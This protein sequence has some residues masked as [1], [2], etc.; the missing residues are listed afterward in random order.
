MNHGLEDYMKKIELLAPVGTKE[1]LVAAV[2]NGADAVYLAGKAF[3]A[4]KFAGNFDEEEMK[5][6][7]AFCHK[8]GVSVFVTVNTLIADSEF[9]QLIEYIDF[10]Y[11]ADVD[12]VIVQDFGVLKMIRQRYPDFE[13]HAST[14]MTAHSTEDMRYLQEQGVKRVVLPR[15]MP[16]NEIAE[17]RKQTDMD[18]ECFVHGALC[19][20]YS[21][22][23]LMS[24]MIGG[25]SGNRGSCAQ[26][27]RQPYS[28]V[29]VNTGLTEKHNSGKYLLSPKDLRAL[30]EVP[31]LIRAGVNSFK[32]EGRMKRP[33][34][35]AVVVRAYRE[36][37][38]AAL[39]KKPFDLKAWNE[40]TAAIFTRGFTKGHLFGDK[41]EDRMNPLWPGHS[42]VKIGSVKNYEKDRKRMKIWI[43]HTLN[44]GDEVQIRRGNESVGARV[45]FIEIARARVKSAA[46]GQEIIMNMQ[47]PVRPGEVIYRTVDDSL[48]KEAR[49]SYARQVQRVEVEIAL[50]IK[51]GEAIT[52]QIQDKEGHR[53]FVEGDQPE[54]A[55]KRPLDAERVEKQIMKLGDSPYFCEAPVINLEDGLALPM[56]SLNALRRLALDELDALRVTRYS[57]RLE[58]VAI[59]PEEIVEP[60]NEEESYTTPEFNVQ[61]RTKEQFSTALDVGVDA[62]LVSTLEMLRFALDETEEN[63]CKVIFAPGRIVRDVEFETLNNNMELLRESAGIWAGTYGVI[64]WA[65]ENNLAV[66]GIDQ[67][68]NIFNSKSIDGH[69][70]E[71]HTVTLSP[72]LSMS[73]IKTLKSQHSGLEAIVY[74]R[75]TVMITEYCPISATLIGGRLDCGLCEQKQYGLQDKK[76][77]TFPILR[78]NKACRTEILNSKILFVPEELDSLYDL[79]VRSYRMVFTLENG[80][81][82]E[83][84][85][86]LFKRTM[87]HELELSDEEVRSGFVGKGIT[88]GH[89]YRGVM[90]DE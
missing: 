53:V 13:I 18:F 88:R 74:G 6:A 19:I 29:D 21:G 71:A 58:T 51:S 8:H 30:E 10:L 85:I 42:G 69:L 62:I 75:Q 68:L 35:A 67:G 54:A 2:W 65:K 34:Y 49:L 50:S 82:T 1:A 36:A 44:V 41:Q 22:Q 43:D 87:D 86:T 39:E 37:I 28:L 72:E 24:S 4:R 3:G 63:Y 55:M 26:S 16:V 76:G 7:V 52:L 38:N 12:A 89:Y 31:A 56:K 25:R 27:C 11:K 90:A 48:L 78:S 15:E 59:E 45:E 77:V 73:Q 80:E 57:E 64:R 61:V 83:D 81:D 79:G 40:K 46:P 20:S 23:C 47:Y 66:V 14:Q 5:D 32:I 60:S 17:I 84:A 70:G 9:A 33:E